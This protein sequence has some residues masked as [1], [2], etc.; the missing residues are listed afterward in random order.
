MFLKSYRDSKY[1]LKNIPSLRGFGR[2]GNLPSQ[3]LACLCCLR[4]CSGS[5]LVKVQ[6][7][8][9]AEDD[10]KYVDDQ[11]DLGSA[12]AWL[13]TKMTRSIRRAV[14]SGVMGSQGLG[15]DHRRIFRQTVRTK[16]KLLF[17]GLHVPI[18]CCATWPE[19]PSHEEALIFALLLTQAIFKA[20]LHRP[21]HRGDP[22]PVA[23]AQAATMIAQRRSTKEFRIEKIMVRNRRSALT[24]VTPYPREP[25]G[26]KERTRHAQSRAVRTSRT[27]RIKPGW[28]LTKYVCVYIYTYVYIHMYINIYI[29]RSVCVYIYV[30]I[31][32]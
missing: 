4:L 19:S 1:E 29:Y 26:A 8:G 14:A 25:R 3:P 18:I 10:A 23:A 27:I 16:S 7:H 20:V 2:F 5:G 17:D 28:T 6:C 32:K 11:D 13:W 22:G 9:V 21:Q 15:I 24:S 12:R 31:D 30:W